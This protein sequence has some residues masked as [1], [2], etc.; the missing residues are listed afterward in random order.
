MCN[1][2]Q[3]NPLGLTENPYTTPVG[4]YDG[5]NPGT[6]DSRSLVGCY[7]MS[8]NVWE[9]C[10]DWF[11]SFT[12][13]AVSN[14]KGPST[15]IHRVVRGGGWFYWGPETARTAYRHRFQPFEMNMVYGFRVAR[16]S[17]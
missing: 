14:P 17:E 12:A 3:E 8:G 5:I 6:V 16:N 7:D 1:Y 15:G 2:L 11:G 10:H 13:E 4:Y 9:W